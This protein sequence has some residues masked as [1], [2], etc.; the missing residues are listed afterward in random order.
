M[1]EGFNN[2]FAQMNV[3]GYQQ[4]HVDSQGQPYYAQDQQYYQQQNYS[5]G[6]QGE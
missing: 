2:Q 4:Q 5:H 6:Y 1:T 3:S